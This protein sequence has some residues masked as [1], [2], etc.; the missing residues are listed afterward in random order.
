M[1][2]GQL[3][4]QDTYESLVQQLRYIIALQEALIAQLRAEQNIAEADCVVGLC[5]LAR[6]ADE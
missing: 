6:H 5:A 4:I 1:G 3:V 2:E